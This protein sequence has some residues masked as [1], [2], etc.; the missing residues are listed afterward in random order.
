[1]KQSRKSLCTV[2]HS[3]TERHSLEEAMVAHYNAKHI[4]LH[5]RKSNRA[6]IS[7]YRD[8]LGFEVHVMEQGYCELSG[9]SKMRSAPDDSCHRCGWGGRIWY[10]IRIY[11]CQLLGYAIT[12]VHPVVNGHLGRSLPLVASSCDLRVILRVR[13]ASAQITSTR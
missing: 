7:L 2:V 11:A 5:V 13:S 4:T 10:A 9:M 1:M 3:D 8:T 12:W 6:A